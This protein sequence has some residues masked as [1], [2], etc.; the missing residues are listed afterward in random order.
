VNSRNFNEDFPLTIVTI[1]KEDSVGL[2][3]TAESIA[4][5]S[6]RPAWLV[7][8]P[9]TENQ[10]ST[11]AYQKLKEG[12]VTRVEHDSGGGIYSAMNYAISLLNQNQWVLFLNAGDVLLNENTCELILK[13]LK[14][15]QG[16]WAFGGHVKA[17]ANG[18]ILGSSTPNSPFSITKQLFAKNFVSHQAFF[19]KVEELHAVGGFDERYKVAADWDLMVKV[20]MRSEGKVLTSLICVFKL[21]GFST[22]MR[23]RSN[24]ELLS[25]RFK[26]LPKSMQFL[27]I[28]WFMARLV[29]NQL[30]IIAES[31]SPSFLNKMRK[32]K[33]GSKHTKAFLS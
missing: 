20:A 4:M 16:K 22:K 15:W 18:E 24:I 9:N 11:L 2:S 23:N 28:T 21:G 10:T 8:C 26:Y 30:L 14:D 13:S 7:V 19:C 6:V 17:N 1:V 33:Y 32:K 25:L 3:L 5:Q 31:M 27:S 29:R 12:V